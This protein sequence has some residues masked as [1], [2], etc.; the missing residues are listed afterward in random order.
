MLLQPNGPGGFVFL[1]A[2]DVTNALIKSTIV[3]L[4]GAAF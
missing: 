1:C 2:G 3:L 4:F